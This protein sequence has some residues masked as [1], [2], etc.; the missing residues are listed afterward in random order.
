VFLVEFGV[1]VGF[2]E[3]F[4]LDFYPHPSAYPEAG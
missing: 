4:L 3:R 1:T 2:A